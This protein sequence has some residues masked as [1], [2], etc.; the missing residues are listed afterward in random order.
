LLFDKPNQVDFVLAD[1][2]VSSMQID[3]PERGFSF[4]KEGPLDL[5]MDPEQGISAAKRLLRM[6]QPELEGM[7]IE[8][9]DEP[10]AV[11][12]SKAIVSEVK[13]GAIIDTTTKLRDIIA[14]ALDF[15]PMSTKE[16]DIKK[17][18]QRSFQALRIDVNISSRRKSRSIVFSFRGR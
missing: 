1:L 13:S 17:S 10:Y 4:K 9:A 5:R 12:I 6:T 18:C 11:E 14:D 8:N 15:L 2:G 7:L 16:H 3:N